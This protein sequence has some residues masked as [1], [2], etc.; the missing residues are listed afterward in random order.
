M[1]AGVFVAVTA[2]AL[3]GCGGIDS[4]PIKPKLTDVPMATDGPNQV[5]V[6]VPGMT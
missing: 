6:Q 5:V 3:A 2:L 4:G 1:R